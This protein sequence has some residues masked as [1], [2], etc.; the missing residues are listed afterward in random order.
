MTPPATMDERN[1]R[2]GRRE[3]EV[4]AK[5]CPECKSQNTKVRTT[6]RI[7]RYCFCRECHNTW[8]Q[9]PPKHENNS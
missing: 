4:R 6:F 7:V 8:T 9:T 2:N 1:Y 3:P 5:P